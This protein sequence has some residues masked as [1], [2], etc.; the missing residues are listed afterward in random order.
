MT[1][2]SVVIPAYNEEDGIRS[3]ME[4]VLAVRDALREVGVDTLELLVVD[5]GSSDR[6]AELVRSQPGATLVQHAKNGGYG[7]ALKTGFAAASGE[8]VGFLDA[9]G[10]YP[11]EYFPAL[12][13]AAKEQDADLVIGSRM[14]GAESQMPI[15]RR[16][17][18]IIFARLVNII[19]ASNITDSAS[20][21]RIFK[22][23]ILA[24]LYP[25]PDGLNLTPVMSTR[26]LHERLKMIEVP[27][28]YS[29]RI[30]RSK[31]SV[32]HDG[33][34]F[35]QSIVWTALNYNPARP[36]GLMGMVSFGIAAVIGLA[37][38]WYR[39]QGVQNV[40]PLGAFALFS[41]LVLSVGGVMLIALGFSFNYF[42]AL[43]HKTPVRQGLW[44][45]PLFNVRW[46]QHFGWAGVTILL[47]GL[48]IGIGSFVATLLGAT[49]MQLWLYYLTSAVFSLMGLQLLVSWVQM[50]TLDALRIRED[51]AASDLLGKETTSQVETS[52]SEIRTDRLQPQA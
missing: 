35:G 33:M 31:L 36:F 32:V 52:R 46:E 3:I 42:V 15:T 8:W 44:G 28:P 25:L 6:T 4:R 16:I 27:I 2:L 37:L 18:N 24:Q 43:F 11:P 50:Q 41:A 5:D 10:T 29:E 40:S 13:K 7:A 34:R 48:L 23:S 22:K 9:D 38:I 49:L 39:L 19:S 26:A 30:G 12:V 51:L 20:G 47:L 45:K 14:A 21:M 17:G 1:T